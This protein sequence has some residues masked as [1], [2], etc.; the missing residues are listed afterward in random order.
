MKRRKR[1]S[2]NQSQLTREQAQVQ[3]TSPRCWSGYYGCMVRSRRF[4]VDIRPCGQEAIFHVAQD[5]LFAIAAFIHNALSQYQNSNLATE[6]RDP[7]RAS[8]S[9][10]SRTTAKSLLLARESRCPA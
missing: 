5:P 10:T 8:T 6:L 3:C 7:F 1:I 2:R 9:R 4:G